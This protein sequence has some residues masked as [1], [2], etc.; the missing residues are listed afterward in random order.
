MTNT[1]RGLYHIDG[2][3]KTFVSVTKIG[4]L[5]KLLNAK[6]VLD[7]KKLEDLEESLYSLVA[8]YTID[9]EFAWVNIE[10]QDSQVA[11]TWG[12]TI[13]VRQKGL[14]SEAIKAAYYVWKNANCT[15]EE[16][17]KVLSISMSDLMDLSGQFER[18]GQ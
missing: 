15:P 10:K 16:A 8:N 13:L 9:K 6:L 5:I 2:V 1:L 4:S 3:D 14:S 12:T 7:P 18:L 17:A 11:L